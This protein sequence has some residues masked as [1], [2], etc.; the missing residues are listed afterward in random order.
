MLWN[1]NI[2]ALDEYRP[3]IFVIASGCT[4]FILLE[5]FHLT[6]YSILVPQTHGCSCMSDII[7]GPLYSMPFKIYQ[8]KK[9]IDLNS[10]EKDW[11]PCVFVRNIIKSDNWIISL[12]FYITFADSTFICTHVF[13]SFF[14]SHKNI[15]SSCGQ[16]IQVHWYCYLNSI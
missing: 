7:F 13:A 9:H 12:L 4:T 3:K 5:P 1:Q 14:A 8:K 2:T 10:H 6:T 16:C 15:L 11:F